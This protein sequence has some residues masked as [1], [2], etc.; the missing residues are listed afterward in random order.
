M[1]HIDYTTLFRTAAEQHVD[2]RHSATEMHFGR[3]ILTGWPLTKLDI[4]ELLNAQKDKIRLPILLLES[5]DARYS[6]NSAD[7]VRKIPTGAIIVLDKVGVEGYDVRDQVID[8]CERIGE[9]CLGYAI[10]QYRKQSTKFDPSTISSEKV[11]PIGSAKL[12]GVR[13]DFQLPELAN[14]SLAY[15]ADKFKL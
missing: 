14:K 6:G 15:Q 8:R 1:R 10:E 13:F 2:L 5:Y 12:W 4:D 3:L 11:G 9:E 7:N